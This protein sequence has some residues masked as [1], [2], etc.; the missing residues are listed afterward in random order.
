MVDVR[1]SEAGY[2][3]AGGVLEYGVIICCLGSDVT[4]STGQYM[5]GRGGTEVTTYRSR[6]FATQARQ[7]E[8]YVAPRSWCVCQARSMSSVGVRGDVVYV[9]KRSRNL[10][11]YVSYRY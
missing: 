3:S 11:C 2:P 5:R 8:W 6:Y 1:C 4:V 7:S 10:G 9:Y